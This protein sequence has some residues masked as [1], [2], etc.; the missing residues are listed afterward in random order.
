[1]VTRRDT[2]DPK[3]TRVFAEQEG[4]QVPLLALTKPGTRWPDSR[5]SV[6]QMGKGRGH[7]SQGTR[8]DT[9]RRD[10]PWLDGSL[11]SAARASSSDARL[12]SRATDVVTPLVQ[13]AVGC[14]VSQIEV[15]W[16]MQGVVASRGVANELMP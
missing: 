2:L 16:V 9:A 8:C 3:S 4:V 15:A 5:L 14:I 12:V 10:A 7:L 1:M 11:G 6:P 13:P